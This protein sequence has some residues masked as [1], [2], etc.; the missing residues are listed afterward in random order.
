MRRFLLFALVL[1][2]IGWEP[3]TGA[4]DDQKPSVKNPGEHGNI[5]LEGPTGLFLNPTSSTLKKDELIVQYCAAILEFKDNNV[6]DHYA[7]GSYGVT[8]WLELG[9][10]GR[11]WDLDD[12]GNDMT[13]SGAGPFARLRVLKEE[14]W[15]PEFSAGAVNVNGDA[16]IQKNTIFFAASKGLGLKERGLPVDARLH[17]GVRQFWFG[18]GDQFVRSWFSMRPDAGGTGINDHVEYLGG[19]IALTKSIYLVSEVSTKPAGANQTP[20]SLGLQ[21]RSSEGYGFSLAAIQPG[22]QDEVGIFIGIGINFN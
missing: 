14:K 11:I 8:D 9:V 1:I 22:S 4:A 18:K 5:T 2:F 21:I 7:I 19:E 17:V 3:G 10:M 16:I 15:L 6:I 20:Y 13:R 12:A